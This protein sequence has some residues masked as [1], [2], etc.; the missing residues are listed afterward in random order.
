MITKS[1]ESAGYL[2]AIWRPMGPNRNLPATGSTGRPTFRR[3][4]LG[5][6]LE[7]LIQGADPIMGFQLGDPVL[8]QRP[9]FGKD[10][11][12]LRVEQGAGQYHPGLKFGK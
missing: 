7:R 11:Q 12:S 8:G 5:E 4:E 2:S 9:P 3:A 1:A 6:N 10:Q